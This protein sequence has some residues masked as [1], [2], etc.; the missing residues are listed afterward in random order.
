MAVTTMVA[1]PPIPLSR[2]VTV[3]VALPGVIRVAPPAKVTVPASAL[4]KV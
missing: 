4:L 2:S 1:M 3:T